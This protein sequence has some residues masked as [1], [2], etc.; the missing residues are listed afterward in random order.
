M[1]SILKVNDPPA[2]KGQAFRMG[3]LYMKKHLK[4]TLRG[5]IPRSVFRIGREDGGLFHHF[6][7]ISS[8][9]PFFR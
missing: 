4:K 7:F 1:L 5:N 2:G 9:L 3:A 8:A 6:L